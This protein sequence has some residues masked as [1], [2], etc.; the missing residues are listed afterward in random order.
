MSVTLSLMMSALVGLG[1]QPVTNVRPLADVIEIRPQMV[2]GHADRLDRVW[3]VDEEDM[4]TAVVGSI[5]A[6][7][8]AQWAPTSH[9]QRER[10]GG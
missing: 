8:N 3:D 7:G 9:N 4:N 10:L 5:D 2:A 6:E 1:P